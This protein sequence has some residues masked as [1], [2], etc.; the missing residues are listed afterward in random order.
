MR[1]LSCKSLEYGRCISVR[2]ATDH[3][4]II[5]LQMLIKSIVICDRV[6][7]LFGK[8]IWVKLKIKKQLKAVTNTNTVVEVLYAAIKWLARFLQIEIFRLFIDTKKLEICDQGRKRSR[9]HGPIV[10][11]GKPH[12]FAWDIACSLRGDLL[13]LLSDYA[14]SYPLAQWT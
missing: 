12:G 3:A 11:L 9:K 10:T 13:W 8:K 1:S 7:Y 2:Y 4:R 14:R 6:I 5:P